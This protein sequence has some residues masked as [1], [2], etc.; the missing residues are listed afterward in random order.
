MTRAFWSLLNQHDA[1]CSSLTLE[2]IEAAPAALSEEMRSLISGFDV[3]PVD[4][5]IHR[6]G[7]AYVKA[8]VVPTRHVADAIHIRAAMFGGADVLVS[9]NFAHRVKRNTR[10][11]VNY[12][13]ATRGL[14]PLEILAPPEV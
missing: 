8:G 9:W 12:V 11:L 14:R 1:L 7:K 4:D 10:L 6:L 2:E 3:V 13:N 5:S